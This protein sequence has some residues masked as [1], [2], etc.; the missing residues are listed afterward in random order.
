LDP[1]RWVFTF[2]DSDSGGKVVDATSCTKGS[3]HHCRRGHEIESKGVV[4][5]ALQFKDVVYAIELVFEAIVTNS[6]AMFSTLSSP[7][8]NPNIIF[9]LCIPSLSSST[10]R[11][12]S[13]D[14]LPPR[15]TCALTES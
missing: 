5:V 15:K 11:N 6:S 3:N 2:K 9:C 14:Q 8:F 12:I 13:Q 1:D 4:E 10:K 7:Q